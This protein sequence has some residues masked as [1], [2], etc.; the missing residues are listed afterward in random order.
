MVNVGIKLYDNTIHQIGNIASASGTETT[1]TTIVDYQ[2]KAEVEVLISEPAYSDRYCSI[3]TLLISNL[4]MAKAGEPRI[5]LKFILDTDYSLN[6]SVLSKDILR[7]QVRIPRNN[8]ESSLKKDK[9]ED[10]GKKGSGTLFSID[11]SIT[12]TGKSR[13]HT[14]LKKDKNQ[15][16][17]PDTKAR[18]IIIPILIIASLIILVFCAIYFFMILRPWDTVTNNRPPE[19]T[20]PVS[21]QETL[22]KDTPSP[23]STEQETATETATAEPEETAVPV[24]IDKI[25]DELKRIGPIYFAPNSSNIIDPGEEKKYDLLLLCIMDY[26]DDVLLIINGHTA[27]AGSE[28][29]RKELSL[30]RALTVQKE[31][32]TRGAITEETS[33]IGGFGSKNPVTSDPDKEYRNRRVE[34]HAEPLK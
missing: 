5:T 31:L 3:G 21:T 2:K 4:P 23:V 25:N 19:P 12:D 28:G 32:I 1:I 16:E 26:K 11:L 30:E 34:L 20:H 17:V 6:I 33:R 10:N 18:D 13:I 7:K 9:H 22:V 15:E 24:D 27:R 14:S 29:E 8:W